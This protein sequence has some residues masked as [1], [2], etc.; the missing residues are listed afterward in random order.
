MN[1][2]ASEPRLLAV[3]LEEHEE[4][5]ALR[6]VGRDA[7]AAASDASATRAW[8]AGRPR[9]YPFIVIRFREP[10]V[11]ALST[12]LAALRK[13]DRCPSV[14]LLA[15]VPRSALPV[16]VT[17]HPGLLTVDPRDLAALEDALAAGLARTATTA[18]RCA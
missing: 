1:R 13:E 8:L 17:D 15:D 9:E 18:S 12:L 6:L 2:V 14:L 11:W 5:V 4:E 16:L 7:V 3:G 10:D